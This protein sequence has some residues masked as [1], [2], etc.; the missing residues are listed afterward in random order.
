MTIHI[1]NTEL[2]GKRLTKAIV[3]ARK[4][5]PQGTTDVIIN[6]YSDFT[7]KAVTEALNE[8]EESEDPG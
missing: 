2:K 4:T 3:R 6:N 7:F 1:H 8:S 5:A